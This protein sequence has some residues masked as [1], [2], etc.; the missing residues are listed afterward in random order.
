M[1]LIYTSCGF[2][3]KK[4]IIG[5]YYIIGVDTD[6]EVSLSYQLSSGNFIG[7]APERLIEYGYNDTFIV[8]KT[9]EYDKHEPTYYLIDMT[10][11]SELAHEDKFRIGPLSETS[12]DSIWKSRLK[13]NMNK[14]N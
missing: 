2:V 10:K 8:A 11:D 3:Y 1:A 14:I 12:F 4:H 6:A 5:K 7:K 13:I 9:Q